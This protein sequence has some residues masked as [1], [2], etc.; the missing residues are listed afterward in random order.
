MHRCT[1]SHI[2]PDS[3]LRH[4]AHPGDRLVSINGNPITDVLDY[5]YYAYD[6]ELAV[7]LRRP[8]GTEHTVHVSKPLGGELGLDFETYLMD[9]AHS[10][11][12]HCVFCFIDQMPPGM[13]PTLYFKDDDAR[14]SFLMGNYMTLTNLS[15]REVQRIIHLHISPINVSVHATDPELR[16]FLLGNPRAGKTLEI[17]RR[18]SDGGI[19][20][21]CQIVC[22]PGLNDGA[23]L[24]RTMHDLAAL[25]PQVHSVSIVPVGLTKFRE[26][27]Y[28][29]TPF[30]P[31]HAAETLDLV[32]AFGDECV[33]KFGAR[34]F[35][36]ADELYLKAGRELP[37]LLTRWLSFVPVSVLAALVAPDLLL[38]DGKLNIAGDN[39]FL[40]ATFPTL[41]ICWYK[42]G[43]LFG[44][45]A[46]GM[47][48]VALI[49]YWM[50]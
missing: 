5:K 41:L 13:R 44:A 17:M 37:P 14:L 34:V 36:C 18:F 48:T 12:N 4:A 33:E 49:R 22:C 46:V 6:P 2:D 20:M 39:L 15:E 28:P 7:C 47:G 26:G 50:T 16:S 45:L 30:T 42:K 31:E 1:I 11:A 32:N 43:S 38:A 8:D 23:Q 19:T 24:Q 3:P 25:Y 27:L 21:N 9:N 29:L 35:F 10:C 40:I